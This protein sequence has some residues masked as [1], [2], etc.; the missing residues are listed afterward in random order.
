[1]TVR[2][3]VDI[4]LEKTGA[5]IPA[6]RTCDQLIVGDFDAEVTKIVSTFIV[7]LDVLKEAIARG[8]NMIITHEPTMFFEFKNNDPFLENNPVYLAK[9][10]LLEE[11]KINIWRF[12]DHMHAEAKDGIYRGL[13]REIDWEKYQMHFEESDPYAH[14]GCCY[15]I[16]EVSLQELA[17]EFKTKLDMQAV[18]VV[19]K[20]DMRVKR[21]S[22]L[23]G[24]GSQGLGD[25]M[26]PMKIMEDKDLDV[27]V[28]GEIIELLSATYVQEMQ[29]L[30]Y[31][32]AML[33]LGHER[34]EEAGMKYLGDWLEPDLNGI[35]VE[36]V[37]AKEPFGYL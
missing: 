26:R 32:R 15:E 11:N 33:I 25:P 17:D 8:A 13:E 4:I 22:I 14:F 30:G 10:K 36:F 23:V 12:H 35:K 5:H 19:G 3:V 18:R 31:N 37:D 2:E 1:M 20:P 27:I 7:T 9:K 28:C 24:G 34:S 16:P 21:V 6:D 29:S